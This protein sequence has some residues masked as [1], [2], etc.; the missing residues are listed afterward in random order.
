[1]S[2]MPGK[3]SVSRRSAAQDHLHQVAYTARAACIYKKESSDETNH[4]VLREL[5]PGKR[6][7][8][9][10]VLCATAAISLPAQTFTTLHR[11][12]LADGD[13]PRAALVQATDGNLYGTTELGGAIGSCG[14]GATCGSVFKITRSG[15][16]TPLFRFDVTEGDDRLGAPVQATDGDFYGTTVAPEAPQRSAPYPASLDAPRPATACRLHVPGPSR[17]PCGPAAPVTYTAAPVGVG[18]DRPPGRTDRA[19]LGPISSR[20][21]KAAKKLWA[22]FGT[23]SRWRGILPPPERDADDKAQRR[24]QGIEVQLV[25][26]SHRV[27]WQL[28]TRAAAIDFRN[29]QR[30]PLLLVACGKD[31]CISAEVQ[32]RNWERYSISPVHTDFALFPDLTHVGIAEP[33]YESLAAYCL[34][35]AEDR[36]KASGSGSPT[37]YVC[38]SALG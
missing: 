9:I 35:W 16:L 36:L 26:E 2:R 11:F 1:M 10:F 19:R 5:D 27:F 23:P 21:A 31:Q 13:G 25:P 17:A 12:H 32:R 38:S 37:E 30:A 18:P 6:A 28:L 7:C 33:G 29:P 4:N 14:P 20:R 34:A 22:L 24:A 8:A 15:T 3:R